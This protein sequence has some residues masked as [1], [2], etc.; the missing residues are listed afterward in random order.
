MKNTKTGVICG[1]HR[2][3]TTYVGRILSLSS[4][5]SVIYEPFNSV[6]GLQ[7]A[8]PSYTYWRAEDASSYAEKIVQKA[9]MF[10]GNFS[11][12]LSTKYGWRKTKYK[13]FG[14]KKHL[15][16]KKLK[17][18][19]FLHMV[20]KHVI[21]KDPFCTF[22]VDYLSRIYNMKIVC[23]I[24]HPCAHYYSVS[25]QNW[26]FDIRNLTRQKKLLTD[27]G[28]GNPEY[29]WEKAKSDNLTSIALLWK[30]MI[31]MM[32]SLN[33]QNNNLMIVRHEDLC[34]QPEVE[35]ERI[36]KFLGVGFTP[37]MRK[38]IHITSHGLYAEA[39]NGN[40]HDYVR[41]SKALVDIWKSKL[42]EREQEMVLQIIGEDIKN[43][44]G[45]K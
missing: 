40:E 9:L 22:M 41:N 44:Y 37:R 38:Y 29:L 14:G 19:E 45:T 6:W 16:W 1:L 26:F 27:Y 18:L 28:T 42:P 13:F 25:K 36:C 15:Q 24:R 10:Q 23:M 8:P 33:K 7:Y 17:L 31:R 32:T 11:K 12:P 30:I 34:I 21:W 39:L 35:V 2:S 5:T 4:S 43:F 20:P 3:G